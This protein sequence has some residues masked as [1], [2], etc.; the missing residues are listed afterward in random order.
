MAAAEVPRELHATLIAGNQRSRSQSAWF[1]INVCSICS[2]VQFLR[3][4]ALMDAFPCLARTAYELLFSNC[5][6]F[7]GE[8]AMHGRSPRA[9][10]PSARLRGRT[11]SV[12]FPLVC[13][14]LRSL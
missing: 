13:C 11:G 4:M 14:S 6:G 9:V 1:R 7:V 8:I 12:N 2:A 3:L 5:N 10:G